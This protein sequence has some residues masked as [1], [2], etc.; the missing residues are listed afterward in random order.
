MA[1]P[2]ARARFSWRRWQL[3]CIAELCLE[4]GL[5]GAGLVARRAHESA[6]AAGAGEQCG[7]VFVG[8][9]QDE[10]QQQREDAAN[11]PCRV[12]FAETAPSAWRTSGGHFRWGG[13]TDSCMCGHSRQVS[14]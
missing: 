7:V 9:P 6:W 12:T 14:P 11:W 1:E 8:A 5:G 3:A 4:A 2:D 10:G 13:R